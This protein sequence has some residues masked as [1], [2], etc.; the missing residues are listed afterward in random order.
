M[1]N[2]NYSE[3]YYLNNFLNAETIKTL[4]SLYYFR[5]EITNFESPNQSMFWEKNQEINDFHI[6]KWWTHYL[7]E[8]F[9]SIY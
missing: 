3:F 9:T 7:R 2:M 8:A 6:K 4:L 1:K 5:F